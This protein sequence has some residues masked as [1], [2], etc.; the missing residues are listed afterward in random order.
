M[1]I[2]DIKNRNKAAGLHFFSPATTRFFRSRYGRTV[3]EGPGG[4]YFLTSE[5]FEWGW[6]RIKGARLYTV[7][8]FNPETGAVGTAGAFNKL[9]KVKAVQ[10][11]KCFA[12]G[13]SY[14]A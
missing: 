8:R 6:G 4:I 1:T 11:A 13:E 12:R 14:G 7:R 5:Q 10:V 2:K 9:G 3:Y